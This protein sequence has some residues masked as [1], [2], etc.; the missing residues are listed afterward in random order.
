MHIASK[1]LTNHR[2]Y[3]FYYLQL[4]ILYKDS[5][6]YSKMYILKRFKSKANS[7]IFASQQ[8]ILH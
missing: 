1:D 4:F 5:V 3:I 8:A 6:N 7:A 2:H